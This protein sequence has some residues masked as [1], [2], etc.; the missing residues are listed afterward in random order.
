MVNTHLQ[1]LKKLKHHEQKPV[2]NN[3]LKFGNRVQDIFRF[4]SVHDHKIDRCKLTKI[5]KDINVSEIEKVISVFSWGGMRY[6]HA[7]QIFKKWNVCTHKS[8]NRFLVRLHQTLNHRLVLL[9]KCQ[10]LLL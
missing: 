5:C 3:V 10:H 9:K 4:S 1:Y 6:D 8:K 7:R 2:G